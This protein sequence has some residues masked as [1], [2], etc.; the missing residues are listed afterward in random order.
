[1]GY[2]KYTDE[3]INDRTTVSDELIYCFTVDLRNLLKLEPNLLPRLI[4]FCL[5]EKR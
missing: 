1:M 4:Y 5:K 2:T 3:V